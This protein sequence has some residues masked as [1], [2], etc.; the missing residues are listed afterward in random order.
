MCY[1]PPMIADSLILPQTIVRPRSFAGLM[2]LYESNYLRLLRMAPGLR[3]MHGEYVSRVDGDCD[4]Y[5]S[6]L[7]RTPYT[8]TLAMTYRFEEAGGTVSDP[9]LTVRVYFDGCLAEAM[10]L[11]EQ[12]H[13]ELFRRLASEFRSELDS[14]WARNVML[15]K[16]LEY[17]LDRSHT[18]GPAAPRPG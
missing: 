17:C 6:V 11:T 4:L 2:T 3:D 16:W 18:F 1:I 15:N 7:E 10:R 8:S 12:H 9:D 14:R 13:H 5:L